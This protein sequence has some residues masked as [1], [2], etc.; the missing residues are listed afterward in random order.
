MLNWK[1]VRFFQIRV[2]LLT[3]TYS[4]YFAVLIIVL[5]LMRTNNLL[6]VVQINVNALVTI[7][8]HIKLVPY[9]VKLRY[10]YIVNII[11]CFQGRRHFTSNVPATITIP[12][13]P[14]SNVHQIC[15]AWRWQSVPARDQQLV[16]AQPHQIHTKHQ[17]NACHLN[18]SV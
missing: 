5:F 12:H 14:M 11:I 10:K 6:Y 18:L 8:L 1:S 3:I 13:L 15:N 7:C 17:E 4:V 16:V 2:L 9:R